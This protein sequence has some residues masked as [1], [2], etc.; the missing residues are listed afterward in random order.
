MG[1]DVSYILS[2]NLPSERIFNAFD[3]KPRGLYPTEVPILPR[4]AAITEHPI[5]A[6]PADGWHFL[7]SRPEFLLNGSEDALSE[8][9]RGGTLIYGEVLQNKESCIASFWDNG[10]NVWKVSANAGGLLIEGEL[11]DMYREALETV[12]KMPFSA[13][14]STIDLIWKITGF[15]FDVEMQCKSGVVLIDRATAKKGV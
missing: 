4:L 10:K 15:R 11:P 8:A 14:D 2:D 7:A 13:I 9:S 3:L 1:V 12:D 5:Y 6:E